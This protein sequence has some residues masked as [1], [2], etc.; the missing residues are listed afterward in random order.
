VPLSLT[1]LAEFTLE[2]RPENFG[3]EYWTKVQEYGA[4]SNE[5]VQSGTWTRFYRNAV[6]H[7]GT[8]LGQHEVKALLLNTVHRKDTTND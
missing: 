4:A 3:A 2:V 8:T 6:D 1:N 7:H 5:L